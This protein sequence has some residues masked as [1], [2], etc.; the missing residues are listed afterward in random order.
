[1]DVGLIGAAVAIAPGIEWPTTTRGANSLLSSI[2]V[3]VRWEAGEASFEGSL[4]R[5][6]GGLTGFKA[7]VW[8]RSQRTSQG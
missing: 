8:H 1:M 4:V 2:S 5:G 6:N 7:I 3:R